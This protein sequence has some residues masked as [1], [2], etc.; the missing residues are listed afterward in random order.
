[1]ELDCWHWGRFVDNVLKLGH[2]GDETKGEFQKD[3]LTQAP[4]EV[5]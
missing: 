4:P 2:P 3:N 1:M 5:I